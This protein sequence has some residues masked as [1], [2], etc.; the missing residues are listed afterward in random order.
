MVPDQSDL[1]VHPPYPA[2]IITYVVL[3]V[4]VDDEF[5]FLVGESVVTRRQYPH[6]LAEH[7][8]LFSDVMN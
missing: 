7:S 6:Q 4:V 5:Q 3:D 1:L 2:E 8:N